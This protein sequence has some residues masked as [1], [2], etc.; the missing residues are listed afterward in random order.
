MMGESDD[1]QEE[2]HS[3]MIHDNMIIYSLMVQA[4]QMEEIRFK[5]RSRDPKRAR[6]FDGVSSKSRLK[7]TFLG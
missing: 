1:L 7:M 2:C 5:R 3:E 4:Q 6:S